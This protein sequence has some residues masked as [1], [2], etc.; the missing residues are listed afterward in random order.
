M[1]NADRPSGLKPVRY[2]NGTP[3]T[4]EVTI[5]Y[6][7]AGNAIYKGAVVKHTGTGST[8][9]KTPACDVAGATDQA[10]GV[11]VG[12]GNTP[13]IAADVTNLARTHCPASTAMYVAVVDD[14]N[15]LFEVQEDNGA[16]DYMET[17]DI[18]QN[19]VLV[20][21][22]TG[23][24]TTGLSS[25]EIDSG[26][27]AAGYASAPLLVVAVSD[28]PNNSMGSSA[29]HTKWL[30]RIADHHYQTPTTGV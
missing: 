15:V 7:A 19:T 27:N 10:I 3:W 21:N 23:N 8:D 4:G 26:G 14:R 17:D 30:V 13:F 18:G 2:L 20:H 24:A 9:G 6:H 25:A 5:Y 28:R 22:S 12:F 29:A 11:A 1:A 16:P